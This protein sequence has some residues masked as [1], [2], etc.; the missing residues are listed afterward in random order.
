[1]FDPI[2]MGLRAVAAGSPWAFPLC[3]V[4][5]TI[6]S[7]GPCA[8]PRLIA[9]TSI[10]GGEAKPRGLHARL[11]AYACG[12]MAVYA[13]FGASASLF[14]RSI[15]LSEIIY[16]VIAAALGVSG[17]AMLWR[18]HGAHQHG[19]APAPSN[20][21]AFLLGASSA[22]VFSPCCTP[23]M[24]AIVAFSSSAGKP[25]FAAAALAAFA[26][27]HASPALALGTAAANVAK[28]AVAVGHSEC[29]RI[30]GGALLLA[31][32]GYY[33]VLA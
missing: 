1:M 22:F 32:A 14:V 26:L 21:G 28:R 12:L 33:A 15:D 31:M 19:A 20:A 25:L 18:E 11:L 5:G 8:A 3:F 4:A 24:L 23:L 27:G 13:A 16:A 2:S 9:I 17:I 29:V 30:V 6:S 10:A 7:A